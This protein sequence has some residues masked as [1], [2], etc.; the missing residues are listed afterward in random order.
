MIRGRDVNG[1]VVVL[2]RVED[3]LGWLMRPGVTGSEDPPRDFPDDPTRA[4]LAALERDDLGRA[5]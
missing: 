3:A 1:G 4:E 5:A 2:S